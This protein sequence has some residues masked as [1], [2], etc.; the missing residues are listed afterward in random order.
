MGCEGRVLR[1]ARCRR[2]KKQPHDLE[3]KKLFLDDRVVNIGSSSIWEHRDVREKAK[4]FP[5]KASVE[6]RESIR[7]QIQIRQM[8]V[9]IIVEKLCEGG[10]S[11]HLHLRICQQTFGKKV[12]QGNER[13]GGGNFSQGKGAS[14]EVGFST[15]PGRVHSTNWE[16]TFAEAERGKRQG[17][18]R[19]KEKRNRW[20][21]KPET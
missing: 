9:G 12:Q 19:E 17:P 7:G 15:E 3:R 14:L 8:A 10:E 21:L 1:H 18:E 5:T 2:R 4:L 6:D 13:T 16:R 11:G 20:T